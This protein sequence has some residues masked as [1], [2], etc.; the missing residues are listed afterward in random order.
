M[1]APARSAARRQRRYGGTAVRRADLRLDGRTL[2]Q[3]DVFVFELPGGRRPERWSDITQILL[4]IEVLSPSTA[5]ADRQV[6]RRRY[7]RHGI[8]EYGS[9]TWTLGW[10]SVGDW[11]TSPEILHDALTWQVSDSAARFE[12]DLAA[13]FGEVL[14]E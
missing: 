8:P 2:V 13:F 6:K 3:P 1:A 14:G 12:L 4:A 10:W 11:E 5:R 7:Q 9:W